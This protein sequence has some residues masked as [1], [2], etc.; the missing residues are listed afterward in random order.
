[1]PFRAA[2]DEI[3]RRLFFAGLCFRSLFF[4]YSLFHIYIRISLLSI[5]PPTRH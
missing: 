3:K 1:L 5:R 2:L 4:F